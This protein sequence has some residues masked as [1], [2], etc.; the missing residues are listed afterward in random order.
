MLHQ[1]VSISYCN[2][3]QE[4][5]NIFVKLPALCPAA[6]IAAQLVSTIHSTHVLVIVNDALRTRHWHP[7]TIL[8]LSGAVPTPDRV[9]SSGGGG[10]EASPPQKREKERRERETEKGEEKR[11]GKREREGGEVTERCRLRE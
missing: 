4:G 5:K 3:Q 7:R 8:Q 6:V 2:I 1:D 11:R 9:S 10:G